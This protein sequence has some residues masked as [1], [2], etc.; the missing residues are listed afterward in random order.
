MYEL[1]RA[2]FLCRIAQRHPQGKFMQNHSCIYAV[3][4]RAVINTDELS[5]VHSLELLT[6]PKDVANSVQ[7][8]CGRRRKSISAVNLRNW[9]APTGGNKIFVGIFPTAR[10]ERPCLAI[11]GQPNVIQNATRALVER[12]CGVR[13]EAGLRIVGTTLPSTLR[14]A[15]HNQ[16]GSH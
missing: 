15:I 12:A 8:M 4:A 11:P 5:Q 10:P 13:R 7:S 6:K 3:C 2:V 16:S 9:R 1:P 14:G